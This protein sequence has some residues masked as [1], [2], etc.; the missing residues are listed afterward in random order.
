MIKKLTEKIGP[1]LLKY[2]V[3]GLASG[4]SMYVSGFLFKGAGAP[5]V[6]ASALA[7]LISFAVSYLL[8]RFWVF[9]AANVKTLNSAVKFAIVTSITWSI[10]LS[11]V[12]VADTQLELKYEWTQL[13]LV[14]IVSGLNFSIN[15][16]WTFKK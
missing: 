8:Q 16:L 2:I 14:I 9:S 6:I 12:W 4:V 7:A 13:V 11:W 1:E 10:G 5:A 15:K 3:S